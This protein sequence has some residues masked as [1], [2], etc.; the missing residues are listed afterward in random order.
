MAQRYL[1]SSVRRIPVR[2]HKRELV[3]AGAGRKKPVYTPIEA[4]SLASFKTK[5][6]TPTVTDGVLSVI[7]TATATITWRGDIKR[8]DR[9]ECLADGSMWEILAVENIDMQRRDANLTL[10]A[11]E[12][13]E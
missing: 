9:A 4:V 3:D 8:G 12:G 13:V 10:R 5:G 6:G 1:D 11:V 2:F 7:S